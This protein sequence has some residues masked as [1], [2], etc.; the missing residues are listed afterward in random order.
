MS[1]WQGLP[2]NNWHPYH[3]D[4]MG[5]LAAVLT[6]NPQDNNNMW[7][8]YDALFPVAAGMV[9]RWQVSESP[10]TYLPDNL[11]VPDLLSRDL[12]ATAPDK[13]VWCTLL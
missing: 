2:T 10:N 3:Y 11:K 6:H 4:K 13:S 5:S 1:I 9:R 8:K 7:K 12:A